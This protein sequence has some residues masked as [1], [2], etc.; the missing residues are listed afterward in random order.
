MVTCEFSNVL[1]AKLECLEVYYEAG[2]RKF[3]EVVERK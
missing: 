3:R 2:E 1:V